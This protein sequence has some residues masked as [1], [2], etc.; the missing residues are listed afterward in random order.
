MILNHGTLYIHTHIV[1]NTTYYIN[2]TPSLFSIAFFLFL[3]FTIVLE[4]RERENSSRHD[5][6]FPTSYTCKS[7]SGMISR[8]R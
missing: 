5:I 8:P 3:F 1:K 7:L 4:E 6:Y 2:I